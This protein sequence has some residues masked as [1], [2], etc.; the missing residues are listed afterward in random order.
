MARRKCHEIT[1][2]DALLKR[3]RHK[4]SERKLRLFMCACCR[5]IWHLIEEPH[6]CAAVEVTEQYV[7]GEADADELADACEEANLFWADSEAEG[8]IN[9]REA[10]TYPADADAFES[11][12]WCASCAADAAHYCDPSEDVELRRPERAAQAALLRCI[13]GDPAGP[14]PFLSPALLAWNEGT[15][16]RL[17]QSIYEDNAFDRIGILADA[18]EEAGCT[19]DAL[20]HLRSPE[21]HVRGCW[22]VDLILGKE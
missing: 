4:A 15:I 2:P 12:L 7:E 10:A 6:C 21:P 8:E 16:P 18:L 22:V 17:A 11:A 9:A 3:L 20:A 19:G 1:D 14:T 5:R 13:F